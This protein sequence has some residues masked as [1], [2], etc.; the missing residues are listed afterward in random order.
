MVD[1]ESPQSY[2]ET[3]A[4][5]DDP[6]IP[7]PNSDTTAYPRPKSIKLDP[8][9]KGGGEPEETDAYVPP[10]HP[11]TFPPR[12]LRELPSRPT[13]R[14]PGPGVPPGVI[15]QPEDRR[16]FRDRNFPWGAMGRIDTQLGKGSGFVVGPRH[17][18]TA[19]HVLDWDREGN[20][21]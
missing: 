14:P 6:S 5:W 12:G 18:M 7:E 9:E 21:G 3:Q 1:R 11:T 4:R 10:G 8:H 16:A 2:E 15:F 17:I 20:P 19:S 13:E